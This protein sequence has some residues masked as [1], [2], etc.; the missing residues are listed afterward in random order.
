LRK[1]LLVADLLDSGELERN[2]MS[3]NTSHVIGEY[4]RKTRASL[5]VQDGCDYTCAYCITTIARGPSRSRKPEDI[6]RDIQAFQMAGYREVVLSGVNLGAYGQDLPIPIDLKDLLSTLLT[7]TDISR[8]RISSLEPW[9]IPVDFFQLWQDRRLCRYLH[10]PLQAGSERTLQR[11]NRRTRLEDFCEL[12]TQARTVMPDVALGSD[13]IVGFPGETD[14]D[15]ADSLAFV[16]DIK[17]CNLHVFRYS[18]RPS[19]PAATMPNQIPGDIKSRRAAAMQQVAEQG[20]SEFCRSALGQTTEVLWEKSLVMSND[21]FLC[22]GL[23]DNAIRIKT[24]AERD[25]HNQLSP[26][27]LE[28][29]DSD[30]QI[31]GVL[32]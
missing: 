29:I 26:V 18:P 31:W 10:L 7:Q 14:S 16:R 20:R 19:T 24:L 11:M 32:T 4:N 5:K 27:L 8:I 30:G 6:V 1:D 28:R 13:I 9:D 17:F 25:L 22:Q 3:H 23:T 2:P 21:T 12:V 15:F